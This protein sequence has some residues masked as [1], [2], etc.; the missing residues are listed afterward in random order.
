MWLLSAKMN[1]EPYTIMTIEIKP[2]I[3][4]KILLIVFFQIE[5]F[6]GENLQK[7]PYKRPEHKTAERNIKIFPKLDPSEW[8]QN[9]ISLLIQAWSQ[10]TDSCRAVPH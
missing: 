8:Q 4:K 9:A 2:N 1:L 3:A 10:E 7:F 5:N 6:L